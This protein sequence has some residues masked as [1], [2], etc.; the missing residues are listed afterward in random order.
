MLINCALTPPTVTTPSTVCTVSPPTVDHPGEAR[1]H[2]AKVK[3]TKFSLPHFNG[4]LMKWSTFG[5]SHESAI[6][7]NDTL[8]NVDEFNYPRSLLEHAAFDAIARLTLSAANYQEAIEILQKRFSN[9]PLIISK[10]MET[11]LNMEPVTSDQSLKELRR[12]YDT[13]ESHLCSLKSLGVE[14][15]SYGAMFSPVLLTKLPPE[16]CLIVSRKISS[17]HLNMDNLLKTF[18][19]ELVARGRASG[20]KTFYPQPCRNQERGQHQ[21]SALLMKTQEAGPSCCYC[22]QSHSLIDYTAMININTRKQMLKSNGRCFN[23]LRKGHIGCNCRSS[24]CRRCSRC[25]HTSI[26]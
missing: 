6:H 21:S 5:D 18:E 4:E 10:H 20:S 23:C 1:W 2:G 15:T 7:T 14:L 17:T 16:L 24:K 3:L 26:C 11:L 8:S 13:T 25:H 22:Q 19:E 12:L 9:K